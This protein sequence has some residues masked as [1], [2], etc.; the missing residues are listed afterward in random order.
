MKTVFSAS[1]LTCVLILLPISTE[2]F[3]L[4]KNVGCAECPEMVTIP[5][6]KFAMGKYEVTFK[7][8]DAC[9]ADGGCGGYQ[10]YDNSW[11]RGA[12]PVINISWNDAQAYIQWISKKTGKPFR[13]PT[14]QEWE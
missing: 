8:W 13:L 11:G 9:V 14:E 3:A 1:L 5:G 2:V 4:E 12:R 7:E 10:P 6:Y